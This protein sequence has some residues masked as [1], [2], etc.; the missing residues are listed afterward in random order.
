MILASNYVGVIQFGTEQKY[1][2]SNVTFSVNEF[3]MSA[4]RGTPKSATTSLRGLLR[5]DFVYA[6]AIVI[7]AAASGDILE[8]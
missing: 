7:A 5:M 1:A 3:A 8:F 4:T 6:M 2:T